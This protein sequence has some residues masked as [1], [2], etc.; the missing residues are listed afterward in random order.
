M[1]TFDNFLVNNYP[2]KIIE[3]HIDEI[4]GRDFAQS[5]DRV[6]HEDEVRENPDRFFTI[7]LPFTSNR[8]E[9]IQIKMR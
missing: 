5:F 2:K 1:E 3:F 9:K 8:C 6:A 7:S 4:K